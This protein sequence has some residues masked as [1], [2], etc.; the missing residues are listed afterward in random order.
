MWEMKLK[1]KPRWVKKHNSSRTKKEE[2]RSL[3]Y[4]VPIHN[5]VGCE[6]IVTVIIKPT[7]LSFYFI[8]V[9]HLHILV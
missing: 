7:A 8:F 1:K 2:K 6:C 3:N 4:I 9:I 5:T